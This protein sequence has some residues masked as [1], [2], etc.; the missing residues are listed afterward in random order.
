[1][2]KFIILILP[3]IILLLILLLI[4]HGIE[5]L[6]IFLSLMAFFAIFLFLFPRWIKFVDKHIKD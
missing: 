4:A 1:M 2:K 5:G 6:I 3:L